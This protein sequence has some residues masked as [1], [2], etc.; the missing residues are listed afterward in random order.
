MSVFEQQKI[1]HSLGIDIGTTTSQVIFSRLVLVNRAS[2]SQIPHY[3]F[4]ERAIIFESEIRIT[5]ID[6]SG[7]VDAEQLFDFV[8]Q[9]FELAGINKSDVETGAIIITGETAKAENARQAVMSLSDAMGDFV[10]ATAGPHLE[11]IIAGRGSG[12]AEYSLRNNC[13]VLNIDIGGGTSNYAVFEAGKV[14][15]SCCLNVGGRLIRMMDGKPDWVTKV[16]GE[17]IASIFKKNIS[18]NE[19]NKQQLDKFVDALADAVVESCGPI[20]SELTNKLMMTEALSNHHYDAVF[21]SGGV[22][23]CYYKLVNGAELEDFNFD[24]LGAHL[25]LKLVKKFKQENFTIK[26]PLQTVRATVIGAGAYSLTLSGS[27]IWLNHTDLPIKNIPVVHPQINWSKPGSDI[28]QAVM[29]AIKRM[30]LDQHSSTYALG[31]DK[32]MPMNYSSVNRV[33]ESLAQFYR[34]HSDASKPIIIVLNNDLG[35]VLGMEMQ[36]HLKN[37]NLAIIDEVFTQEGDYVDIGKSYFGG[38][39]VPLTVKSLAFPS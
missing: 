29:T 9:Q 39:I 35:K 15:D 20:R 23:D 34:G 1:I 3:E 19:L 24:D 17:I 11:S 8:N 18:A 6:Q 30:D 33:A 12:A 10:V 14:A 28:K 26:Q 37:R 4:V 2:A 21:I 25:A 13:T 5:P 38:D 22:G 32:T 16:G 31:I 7:V 27:T 36:G